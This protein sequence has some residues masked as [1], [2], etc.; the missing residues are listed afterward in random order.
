M[1][2]AETF[3]VLVKAGESK[4]LRVIN[5]ALNTDL[6]F[7][8]GSHI[9]TVVAVDALHTKPFQTNFLMLGPRQTTDVLVTVDKSTGKYYMVA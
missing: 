7:A 9:M 6:F 1:I 4:L 5:A 2:D 3:R 8:V